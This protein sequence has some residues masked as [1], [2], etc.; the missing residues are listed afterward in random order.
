MADAEITLDANLE[1]DLHVHPAVISSARASAVAIA[2]RAKE[3]A[4][5]VTGA[6]RNGIVVDP[7]SP[8]KGVARVH[9]TDQKSSWVEFG[10][11]TQP[12]QFIIRSA[13]ESLGFKFIKKG[14]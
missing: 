12:G 6:Y 3:M 10:T 8:K 7:P 5:V 13:A 1:K 4:P 14:G 2:E 11:A 9:G